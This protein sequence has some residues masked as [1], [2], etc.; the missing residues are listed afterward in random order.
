[1]HEK[2]LINSSHHH[3][4]SLYSP[5]RTLAAS[6]RRFFNLIKTLART[7]LDERSARRKGLYLHKTTQ[8]RNTNIHALSVI[9]IL[10][11]SNQAAKTYALGRAATEIGQ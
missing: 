7:P 2:D 11:P 4:Q 5:L 1:M 6:H 8:H 10:D 3:H 9:R